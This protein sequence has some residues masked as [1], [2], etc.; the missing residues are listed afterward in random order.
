MRKKRKSFIQVSI[1]WV[2]S[3][4]LIT[5]AITFFSFVNKYKYYFL[6]VLTLIII[7]YILDGDFKWNKFRKGIKKRFR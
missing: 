1:P 4:F 7:F 5:L 2:V 3:L 6:I